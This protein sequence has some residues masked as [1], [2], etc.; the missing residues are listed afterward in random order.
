MSSSDTYLK[1]KRSAVWVLA[2]LTDRLKHYTLAVLAGMS[3]SP[4]SLHSIN[5][6]RAFVTPVDQNWHRPGV[7]IMQAEGYA[8]YD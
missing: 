3:D 8:A 2:H 1:P 4:A 5:N 7:F 6:I